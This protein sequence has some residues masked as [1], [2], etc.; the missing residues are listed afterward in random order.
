MS[1]DKSNH[2][3]SLVEQMKSSRLSPPAPLRAAR[4]GHASLEAL[5]MGGPEEPS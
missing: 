4:L 5:L 3:P 2:G 1:K